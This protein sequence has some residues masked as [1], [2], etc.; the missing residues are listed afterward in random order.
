MLKILNI[1]GSVFPRGRKLYLKRLLPPKP[2]EEKKKWKP[3]EI[4]TGYPN[5]PSYFKKTIL[6]AIQVDR[7][8]AENTFNWRNYQ[9][10]SYDSDRIDW[11]ILEYK[12]K[13]VGNN[14]SVERLRAWQAGPW[15]Y[16][17]RLLPKKKRED[18]AKELEQE[19]ENRR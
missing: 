9:K 16:I 6:L 4:A 8:C 1:P 15:K 19:I 7:E 13:Y 18:L 2:Q 12:K 17:G 14:P 5:N 3:Q 10:R 11:L